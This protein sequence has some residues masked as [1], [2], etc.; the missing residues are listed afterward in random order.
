MRHRR[1]AVHSAAL[2]A[3]ALVGLILPTAVFA[4]PPVANPDQATIPEDSS[5]TIGLIKNDTD[6]D[7]DAV[8]LVSVG[9]PSHGSVTLTPV[10]GYVTYTPRPNFNGPDQFSYVVGDTNGE[11][12]TG[13][14]SILV[15]PVNDPPIAFARVAT[16]DENGSVTV[17][18]QAN[19]PDAERCDLVFVT[20]LQP[21]HGSLTAVA[22]ADCSP[23]GDMANTTYTPAPGFSGSDSFTYHA[24]DGTVQS[25]LATVS[26]TV[27]P[28]PR[29][30]VGD[31][32]A[33]SV[34]GSGTWSANTTIR[35]DTAA[36]GAQVQATVRGTWSSGLA[37]SCVTGGSGTC[38]IA[39]G[40]I[41]RSVKTATFTV[42]SVTAG[43]A[44][45]VAGANHDPDGDST[46]TSITIAR[47]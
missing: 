45:Y 39:S 1:L 20:D 24:S 29:I 6:P 26:I 28:L 22:D 47:P 44:I 30:H 41:G 14:V 21:A 34:K 4:A 42:T 36:H 8:H 10:Q 11:T 18:L 25:N 3:V 9:I 33:T 46:G 19:D 37:G 23:N 38:A 13:T 17:I 7:G 12:A 2:V 27:V 40:A 35:I 5:T 43:L 32:D 31:L 15:T 16:V